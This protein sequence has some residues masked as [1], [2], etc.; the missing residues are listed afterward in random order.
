TLAQDGV[1]SDADGRY[2]MDAQPLPYPGNQPAAISMTA[3]APFFAGYWPGSA[4]GALIANQTSTV[5]ID[6]IKVC[7]GATISG[8]VQNAVTGLPIA[9][10][11]VSVSSSQQFLST[12]TDASGAFVF[13]PVQVGTDN[14]PTGVLVTASAADFLPRQ[15]TVTVFCGASI[16]VNF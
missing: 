12:A 5:D 11:T 13:F 10:A 2:T 16:Q 1:S 9:G 6:L 15:Q 8:S 3:S 14:T 4:N 7:T